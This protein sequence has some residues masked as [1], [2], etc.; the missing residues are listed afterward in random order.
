MSQKTF[1]NC[2]RQASLLV[3]QRIVNQAAYLEPDGIASIQSIPRR[4]RQY[5]LIL[6]LP[7]DLRPC[8]RGDKILVLPGDRISDEHEQTQPHHDQH[9][10]EDLHISLLSRDRVNKEDW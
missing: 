10:A 8:L 1:F 7:G 5:P 9:I 4:I 3:H 2:M 6:K